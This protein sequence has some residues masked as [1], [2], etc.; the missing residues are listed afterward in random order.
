M[1]AAADALDAMT[2]DR[3]Y[4]PAR[5]WEE[6]LQQMRV[7]AGSQFD[8]GVVAALE[9]TERE[10]REGWEEQARSPV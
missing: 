8:P 5:A 3:A 9:R 10:L 7:L 1:V 6:A 4:R 2:S